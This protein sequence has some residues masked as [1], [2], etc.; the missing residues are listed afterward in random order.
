[1]PRLAGH[2]DQGWALAGHSALGHWGTGALGIAVGIVRIGIQAEAGWLSLGAGFGA[3]AG[4]GLPGGARGARGAGILCTASLGQKSSQHG[5]AAAVI[6]IPVDL[7]P[8]WG[9]NGHPLSINLILS[10]WTSD[11][12][13]DRF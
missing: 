6:A 3:G 13:I 1:M 4:A 12:S 5:W 11:H 2:W 7:I 8:G 10:K 9:G